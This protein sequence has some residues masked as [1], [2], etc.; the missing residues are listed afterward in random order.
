MA[1][2]HQTGLETSLSLAGS[3]GVRR[4]AAVEQQVERARIGGE[5]APEQPARL[6]PDAP[7]P[8]QADILH[9][10]RRAPAAAGEEVEQA[11]RCL[12]DADIGQP[13]RELLDEGL[14]IGN[15]KP[16]PEI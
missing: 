7:H 5:I 4:P 11:S 9:P 6:E 1:D 15:A 10:L 3:A 12:D 2:F 8:F 16:N 13:R 14:L